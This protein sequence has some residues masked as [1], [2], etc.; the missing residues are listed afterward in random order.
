MLIAS[1]C[2]SLTPTRPRRSERSHARGRIWSPR[3]SRWAISCVPSFERFWPG[4][5]RLFSAIDSSI[6]L[7]FLT[8]YPS[9]HDA[10]GLGEKRMAAFLKAHH[11]NN[12]K[13][14]AQLLERLRSAPSGRAGEIETRTRRQ[15][16]L[17]LTRTLQTMIEQIRELEADDGE[18]LGAHPDGKIFRSFF[19]SPS[20]VICAATLLAEIGD[21]RFELTRTVTRSPP[22]PARHPSPSN[23]AN[24]SRR[25]SAGTCNKRLRNAIGTLAHVTRQWNPWAAD[26]YDAAR[27]RG[28]N[29]RRALPHPR[30]RVEPDPLAL[31][32][33][34]HPLRPETTHRP[35]TTH[36][37]HHQHPVGPPARPHRHSANGPQR[38]RPAHGLTQDVFGHPHRDGAR[39]CFGGDIWI[40]GTRV[41]GR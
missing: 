37:R 36:H 21:C 27:A 30:P 11:Y 14:A 40:A 10:R 26:R 39:L 6:S 2:W 22:R 31:L 38:P 23:P 3:G 29:H 15:I 20:S 24:A 32:A 5:I 25:S 4:P 7:A 19:R 9:P 8:R 12:S 13:T 28:H 41:P 33:N 1:G 17:H 18:A 34:P 16:V 35:A